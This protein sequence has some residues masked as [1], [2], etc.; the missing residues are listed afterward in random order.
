MTVFAKTILPLSALLVLFAIGRPASAQIHA[1][2]IDPENNARVLVIRN[3]VKAPAEFK[4]F[5][6]V[7]VDVAPAPS[8]RLLGAVV[9]H[10]PGPNQGKQ[11]VFRLHIVDADGRTYRE[12][13]YVQKFTFS[14]DEQYVAV[15]RGHGYE[16]GAGFFPESVEILGLRG[17]DLGPIKGLEKATELEWS[18]F[19]DDGMVLL[20]RV[21]DG[22]TTIVEYIVSTGTVVPTYFLGLHFSPDGRYYYLTPGEALRANV[23]QAGLAYDSCVRIYERAGYFALPLE[24]DPNLRRPLGW[25]DGHRVLLANERSHECQVFDVDDA[26]PAETFAAVDWRWASRRGI[27]MRRSQP[28]ANFRKVG[29]PEVQLLIQ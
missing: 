1:A 27:V 3:D 23:C 25:A 2:R 17:P 15:I 26:R 9:A 19:S 21:F 12:V 14:P 4:T 11:R 29:K 22:R 20:A 28:N 10:K 8:G 5:D 16:G 7:V 24:L 18:E 6:G 13:D